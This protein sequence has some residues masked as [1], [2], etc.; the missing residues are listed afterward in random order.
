MSTGGVNAHWQVSLM[1]GALAEARQLA[2]SSPDPAFNLL[3]IDSWSGNTDA[4]RQLLAACEASPLNDVWLTWCARVAGHLGDLAQAERMR[5]LESQGAGFTNGS[6]AARIVVAPGP[7][8]VLDGQ[9]ATFWGTFTYRRPT[10][11]DMLLP[12]I[13]HITLE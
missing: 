5:T 2:A 9:L 7:M 10:P 8:E 11:V 4:F 6:G 12:S 1:T 13:A 3:L